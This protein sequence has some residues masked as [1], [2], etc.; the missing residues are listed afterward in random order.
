MQPPLGLSWPQYLS[1]SLSLAFLAAAITLFVALPGQEPGC[2]I[3][4]D[5]TGIYIKNRGQ[6]AEFI[7]S[8]SKL[9]V[10]SYGFKFD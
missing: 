9:K 3:S 7:Q 6:H 2:T 8:V 10:P 4:I 5:G 1:L